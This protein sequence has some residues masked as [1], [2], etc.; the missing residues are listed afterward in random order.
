MPSGCAASPSAT[1]GCR[2]RPSRRAT[3]CAA[4]WCAT[5]ART[6][7]SRGC[8]A[9]CRWSAWTSCP[10]PARCT[11]AGAS[12]TR[13]SRRRGCRC[14]SRPCRR[15]TAGCSSTAGSWT[16]CRPT[17]WSQRDEGPVVA[18]N[19]GAGGGNRR[20]GR[21]RVPALGDT[22]MRTMMIG[23][24]GA[25]EA[26]RR[27]GA[28]VVSPSSMGV[29]LLEFHQ[30]DRMIEAGRAAARVLLEQAGGDLGV[31]VHDRPPRARGPSRS[32]RQGDAD[33][34]R[35]DRLRV[36]RLG[37][38]DAVSDE[39]VRTASRG[40]I[41]GAWPRT[42]SAARHLPW[43]LT[44]R[45]RP[46]ARLVPWSRASTGPRP[47]TPSST[48]PPT[49][50]PGSAHRSGS[51]RPSTP[52]CSSPRTRR[53]PPARRAWPTTSRR[54]RTTFSTAPWPGWTSDTR[55]STSRRRSR[56][57]RRCR[58]RPAVRRGAARRRRRSGSRP[59]PATL[60][61][62]G[63]APRRRPRALPGGRRAREHRDQAAPV[64][65]S[66]GSTAAR[67]APRRSTSRSHRRGHGRHVIAVLGWNVE[68][69]EGVVVT[70]PGSDRWLA[71]EA[72]HAARVH[73]VLDPLAAAY[74]GCRW[75]CSCGTAHRRGPFSRWRA[76]Q[77][78]DLV[79]VGSRGLGASGGCCSAR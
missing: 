40:R 71:V 67:A 11:A 42:W 9:S 29:G 70:E 50:R 72:R 4:R 75:R 76:E 14:S 34:R 44:G 41:M 59:A 23:S 28:W 64:A 52:G 62:F 69:H 74:P 58:R 36:E 33:R 77:E 26:A 8:R 78:A 63:G 22:L 12:S 20:S 43:I 2:R 57:A 56:G 46:A 10:A 48:G 49:R 53:S 51:C 79:V 32:G 15:T 65:S 61:G 5:W 54:A 7:S 66:S 16:T 35:P 38:A 17:S 19:I 24:G 6:A 18:V 60:H 13:P 3:A 68:V 30:L 55:V 45:I 37:P 1:G 27:R 47:T 25:V 21:P 31:P 73:A 39:T